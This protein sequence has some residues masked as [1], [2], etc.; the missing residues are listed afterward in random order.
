M[1][2]KT[3]L[4]K[5]SWA[6]IVAA[7][8][9]ALMFAFALLGAP[10][11]AWA[12]EQEVV[13]SQDDFTFN[14]YIDDNT[15]E[16]N[17][18]LL[19]GYTGSKAEVVLPTSVIYEGKEHAITGVDRAFEGNSTI[20]KAVIP[21]G[22]E[23]VSE[24]AFYGCSNLRS[25]VLGET[26]FYIG[27]QA[28]ANCP[29]LKDY[30]IGFSATAEMTIGK[31]AIG[32]YGTAG[33]EGKL[34]EEITAYIVE[35]SSVKAA[36]DEIN[37]KSL[38]A[39][40]G[41]IALVF[42]GDPAKEA[43]TTYVITIGGS[44]SSD[45]SS[46]GSSSTGDAATQMGE[47]GTALG[48]GASAQVADKALIAFKGEADPKGAVYSGLQLKVA[49]TTKTSIKLTWKKAAK[50]KSYVL[51]ANKCG[52]GNKYK[53]LAIIAGSKNTALIKKVASKKV[54]K[55]TYYKF[56][57]VAVNAAKGKGNVVSTSKTV[58]VATPGGT[59]GNDKKVTTAAKKGKVVLKKG[60]TFR[61]KAKAVPASKKLRVGRHRPLKYE[62]TNPKIA[63]V[64]AKGV[65][66]G[67]KK[68]S[69][70]VYAYAQNGVAAKVKVTV[71]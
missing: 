5:T 70:F 14:L 4:A 27:P 57:L 59:V 16:V 7:L 18:L 26:V 65:I 61:L 19:T 58:H 2:D 38:A 13:V 10:S 42:S 54:K 66:K 34:Y 12:T 40:G 29:K 68:G 49:K 15:G 24:K 21:N 36:I 9:C 32:A 37:A 46:A 30:Y 35:G 44:S 41:T 25:V 64:S 67:V 51:Y 20:T 28:F 60:K 33:N 71:R 17:S 22:Y 31:D 62:S 69:C 8:A 43:R 11:K 52:K 45:P 48:K 3:L 47:D 1:V 50:A 39:G 6:Y 55:G 56:I 53:K 23:F 63:K